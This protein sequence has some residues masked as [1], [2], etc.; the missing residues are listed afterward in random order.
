MKIELGARSDHWPVSMQKISPYVAEVL[1]ASLKKMDAEIR[2]LNIARTFWEKA[3]ILHMYAHYPKS[4]TVPPLVTGLG[5]LI[6]PNQSGLIYK[7]SLH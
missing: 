4:N 1:P 5:N 2:V 3:T 6:R 7:R